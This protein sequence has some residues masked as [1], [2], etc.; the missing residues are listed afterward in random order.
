M[1]RNFARFSYQLI[2]NL[3]KQSL[4]LLNLKSRTLVC[5][6]DF[7]LGNSKFQIPVPSRVCTNPDCVISSTRTK[8]VNI[9]AY[10]SSQVQH[11]AVRV[12]N[13][14]VY[15]L[16]SNQHSNVTLHTFIFNNSS[17]IILCHD[18]PNCH[19]QNA[20]KQTNKWNSRWPNETSKQPLSSTSWFL[21]STPTLDAR[22]C[23]HRWTG[24]L[25]CKCHEPSYRT[26]L[27]RA[28]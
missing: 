2:N 4:G 27:V 19:I 5:L 1:Q 15:T 13:V 12:S 17:V 26:E 25:W 18:R 21:T 24:S 28:S 9:S 22:A 11:C 23:R 8:N 10:N 20:T 7:R 3:G 6:K 16:P 14:H